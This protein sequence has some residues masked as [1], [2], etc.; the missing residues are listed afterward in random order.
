[1]T[2][3]M[4]GEMSLD[5]WDESVKKNTWNE[6][7]GMRQEDYSKDTTGLILLV[8]SL[9]TSHLS[10]VLIAPVHEEMEFI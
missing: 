6:V 10:L 2:M 7:D 5:D 1:M 8:M 4:M 3:V 9:F